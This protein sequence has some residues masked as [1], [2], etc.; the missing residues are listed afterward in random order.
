M[1]ILSFEHILCVDHFV[2]LLVLQINV[3][4]QLVFH[5]QIALNIKIR[6]YHHPGAR[7]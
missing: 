4:Q 7:C 5:V 1:K 3:I 2:F 6:Y